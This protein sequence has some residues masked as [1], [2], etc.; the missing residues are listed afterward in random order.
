MAATVSDFGTG[1]GTG[2]V[3]SNRVIHRIE[4]GHSRN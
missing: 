4:S 2:R 1:I 3:E